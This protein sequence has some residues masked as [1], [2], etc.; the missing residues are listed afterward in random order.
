MKRRNRWV[1]S[2][3][4]VCAL[5][6]SACSGGGGGTQTQKADE[7]QTADTAAAGHHRVLA[8]VRGDVPG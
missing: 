2:M 7:P 4:L 5:I 8:H 6:M 1:L 3:V